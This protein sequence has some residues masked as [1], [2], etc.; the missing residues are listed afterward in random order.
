MG[1]VTCLMQTWY[2]VAKDYNIFGQTF[3]RST[4]I[5]VLSEI[6]KDRPCITSVTVGF[7]G[8]KI[9]S[10]GEVIPTVGLL[11][12]VTGAVKENGKL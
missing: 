2:L 10:K 8:G 1:N 3:R 5:D 4:V 9:N 6:E 12:V 7:N 11:A